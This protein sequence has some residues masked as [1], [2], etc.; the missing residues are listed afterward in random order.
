MLIVPKIDPY[1]Y[2]SYQSGINYNDSIVQKVVYIS[3]KIITNSY[4]FLCNSVIFFANKLKLYKF[5]KKK[6][7]M[8]DIT[9]SQFLTMAFFID[10]I[11]KGLTHDDDKAFTAPIDL[12]FRAI[13]CFNQT[14][15]LILDKYLPEATTQPTGFDD[16][17]FNDKASVAKLE[18]KHSTLYKRIFALQVL[19]ASAVI[20]EV[21]QQS[22][23]H[24]FDIPFTAIETYFIAKRLFKNLKKCEYLKNSDPTKAFIYTSI[25]TLDLASYIYYNPFLVD[26]SLDAT[27]AKIYRKIFLILL[28]TVGSFPILTRRYSQPGINK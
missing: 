15:S 3:K 13:S 22:F 24:L 11:K 8:S 19:L 26:K 4:Y 17:I 10:N 25:Y 1:N 28:S 23:M 20:S 18:G 14:S 7:S 5:D 12:Y 27:S 16:Y 9:I 6:L 21:R 2:Y